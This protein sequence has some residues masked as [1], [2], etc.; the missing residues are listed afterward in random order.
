MATTSK[1]KE[2]L[3]VNE[4]TGQNGTVIYHDLVMENGDKI[5]IGKKSLQKIGWSLDYE[6]T[7]EVGQHEFTKA[8]S[9]QPDQSAPGHTTQLNTP[10]PAPPAQNGERVFTD[11]DKSIIYQVCLKGA[12][13]VAVAQYDVQFDETK[14]T[15]KTLNDMALDM[16]LI[17]LANMKTL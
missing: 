4:W 14:I 9:V 8:K 10:T 17:A 16:T 13:E 11:T 12:V 1:I 6:L 2:V 7:D 5:N 15:P 3:N